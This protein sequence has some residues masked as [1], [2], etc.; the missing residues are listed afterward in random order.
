MEKPPTHIQRG[1]MARTDDLLPSHPSVTLFQEPRTPT[2]K[3]GEQAE[4]VE[5]QAVDIAYTRLRVGLGS[6]QWLLKSG[7]G[8]TSEDTVPADGVVSITVSSGVYR[9]A[10]EDV[11][12]P[13]TVIDGVLPATAYTVYYDGDTESVGAV[14]T[15][16]R[17]LSLDFNRIPIA[18]VLTVA[19]GAPPG[20]GT[21]LQPL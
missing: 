20:T 11:A 21:E 13:A 17:H 9:V 18:T 15:A 7:V 3:I 8:I 19:E 2:H 1:V 5:D 10:G 12:I 4:A 14:L 16:N 6:Q